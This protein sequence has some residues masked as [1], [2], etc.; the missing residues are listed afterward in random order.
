MEVDCNEFPDWV[1]WLACDEDGRWWGYE[2]EPNMSHNGWYENEVG[3]SICLPDGAVKACHGTD[4]QTS[5]RKVKA[6]KN[7]K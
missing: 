5:V 1:R 6:D 3:R 2:V 4:W 7:G